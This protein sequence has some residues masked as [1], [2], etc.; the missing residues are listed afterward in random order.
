[1]GLFVVPSA[2]HESFDVSGFLIDIRKNS[3]Q[4]CV[5]SM[6]FKI[7]YNVIKHDMMIHCL[8]E[9]EEIGSVNS[10][11]LVNLGEHW[12]FAL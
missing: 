12:V 3:I 2:V 1:M 10:S 5:C 8:C 7:V 9:A 6:M 4:K 11:Y